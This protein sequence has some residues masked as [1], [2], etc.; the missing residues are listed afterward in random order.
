MAKHKKTAKCARLTKVFAELARIKSN[1]TKPIEAES[2]HK[3]EEISTF[4]EKSTDNL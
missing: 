3:G 4:T 2:S 1:Y